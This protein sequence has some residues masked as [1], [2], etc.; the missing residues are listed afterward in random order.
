MVPLMVASPRSLAAHLEPE[1][2]APVVLQAWSAVLLPRRTGPVVRSLLLAV[3][4]EAMATAALSLA[5]AVRLKQLAPVVLS[6]LPAVL[7]VRRVAQ[8]A[9]HL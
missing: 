2:P 4:V 5:L 7:A 3:L 1:Q 6:D 9:L 8:V